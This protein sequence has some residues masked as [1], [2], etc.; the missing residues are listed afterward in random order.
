MVKQ[1]IKSNKERGVQIV[2]LEI[3]ADLWHQFKIHAAIKGKSGSHLIRQF[4]KE[5]VR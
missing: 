3:D 4:L 2:T 1:R 5:A